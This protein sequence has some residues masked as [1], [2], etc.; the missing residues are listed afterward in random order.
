MERS[1]KIEIL[2]QNMVSSYEASKQQCTAS[3]GIY[4]I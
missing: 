3:D 1:C 4:L 2:L